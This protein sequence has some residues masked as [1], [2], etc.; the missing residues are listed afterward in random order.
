MKRKKVL[1]IFISAVVL[2]G[3]L[4]TLGLAAYSS[5]QNDQDVSN[6]LMDKFP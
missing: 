6:F 4:V 1:G 5:H 3:F 2:A